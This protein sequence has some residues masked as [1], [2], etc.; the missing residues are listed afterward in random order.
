MTAQLTV[1]ARVCSLTADTIGIPGAQGAT[2]YS[3]CHQHWCDAHQHA[4]RVYVR[5]DLR[6]VRVVLPGHGEWGVQF[7]GA[8]A[9]AAANQQHPT[10][11]VGTF[12]AEHGSRQC[13]LTDE[14]A[15]TQI[16]QEAI[17][18]EGFVGVIGGFGARKE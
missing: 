11:V 1:I 6:A 8:G 10:G 17:A 2:D 12:G 18:D 3:W 7:V 4:R 9:T 5:Y 15:M 16:E 14:P 13:D